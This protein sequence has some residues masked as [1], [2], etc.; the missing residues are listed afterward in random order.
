M[1]D[2]FLRFSLREQI[3]LL[4][5]AAAVSTYII[6]VVMLLPLATARDTL[7]ENNRS[8]AQLLQRVDQM[9]AEI[10]MARSAGAA[11][12][13]GNVGA[14]LTA[15]L[16]STADEQGLQI[17]RVQPNSR[18]A[19]QLRFE[20]APLATLLRWLHS[21]EADEGFV[22]EEL[23]LGQTSTAGVVTATLRVASRG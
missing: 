1:K 8:T 20:A 22:I 6:V 17:S 13:P 21:L 18:G 11:R 7:R 16:N 14:N 4:L 2:W 5:M 10:S 9:A 23:S 12:G 3:A 19:V 15:R